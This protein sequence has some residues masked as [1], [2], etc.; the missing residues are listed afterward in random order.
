VALSRDETLAALGTEFG[1]VRI[2]SVPAGECITDLEAHHDSVESIAFS[3]DGDLLVTGS[4]DRTVRLWRLSRDSFRKLL[5]LKTPA[6]VVAVRLSSNGNHLAVLV[7]NE[8][9]VRI[10]GLHMLNDQ[11]Q[12]MGLEWK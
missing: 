5:A 3:R 2:V 10:W 12:R 6:P 4:A 9:A 8:S 11:L 1:T 7:K